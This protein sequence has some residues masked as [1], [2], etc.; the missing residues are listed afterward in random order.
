MNINFSSAGGVGVVPLAPEIIWF[1]PSDTFL[2]H[3]YDVL[4]AVSRASA[5]K[6]PG[7]IASVVSLNRVALPCVLTD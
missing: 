2:Q 4:C 6:G 3:P 7:L 5:K 1:S